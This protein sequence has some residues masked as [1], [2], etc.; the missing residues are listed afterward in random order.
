[1]TDL[2]TVI[3]TTPELS[4]LGSNYPAIAAWL[5]V[6]PMID[7]PDPQVETPKRITMLDVFTAIFA[8][9]PADLA[10]AGAIPSWMID[11]AEGAMASNDRQSMAN[12]LVSIGA[13][14]SLSEA[15]TTALA[16][17]L[18]ATEPD[19]A[20]QATVPGTPRWQ[21]LGLASAPTASD[22]QAALNNG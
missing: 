19:P 8:A 20:W 5:A 4:A 2:R 10:K 16:A 14:A 21:A 6:T 12:W 18:A 15:A 1:M 7:N 22:V 11:R 3:E 17:L 13:V 9:A